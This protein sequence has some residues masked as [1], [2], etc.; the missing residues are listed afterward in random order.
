MTYIE[1]ASLARSLMLPEVDLYLQNGV[2]YPNELTASKDG[3]YLAKFSS[4]QSI[5][6]I[7]N[8]IIFS[9][10]PETELQ[11]LQPFMSF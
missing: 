9:Q 7:S 4:Q 6:K 5:Y 1:A 10:K 8:M 2:A 11:N 3:L